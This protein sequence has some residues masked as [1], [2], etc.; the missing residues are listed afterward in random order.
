MSE[1]Q[2]DLEILRYNPETDEAPS[3]RTYRVPCQEDW[4]V[5]D[6]VNYVK[7]ELDRTLSYRWSCHMAV[8]GSCGMVVNDNPVLSCKAF[9]RDL[10]DQNRRWLVDGGFMCLWCLSEIFRKFIV[11]QQPHDQ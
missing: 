4:V 2:V 5:L 10:P 7:D 3:F 6:A 8:C 9:L 1:R 11:L